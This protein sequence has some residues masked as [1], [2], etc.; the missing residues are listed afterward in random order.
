MLG[1]LRIRA[2]S[3]GSDQ[4][5]QAHDAH[6]ARSTLTRAN[7]H[8]LL[9]V[10]W[11]ARSRPGL[12]FLHDS[13]YASSVSDRVHFS[14]PSDYSLASERGCRRANTLQSLSAY[15]SHAPNLPHMAD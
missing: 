4:V 14:H 10:G 13:L 5:A 7:L 9:V 12:L 6:E 11:A 2:G 3:F 15:R 8:Q 1:Y